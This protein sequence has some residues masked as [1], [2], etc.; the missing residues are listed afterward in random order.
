MTHYPY[1]D[2]IVFCIS[3]IAL[4]ALLVRL[5]LSRKTR[6]LVIFGVIFFVIV[7]AVL[8]V[9]GFVLRRILLPFPYL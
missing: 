3:G 1:I 8:S 7:I 9:M 5:F 4:L 6:K 2:I